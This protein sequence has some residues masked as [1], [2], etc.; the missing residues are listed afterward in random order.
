MIKR[1]MCFLLLL[2]F[3]SW[4]V[5]EITLSTTTEDEEIKSSFPKKVKVE[6][7]QD[8][9]YTYGSVTL[10]KDQKVTGYIYL[11]TV[12]KKISYVPVAPL[13][14]KHTLQGEVVV[15]GENYY[16]PPKK[17]K[18]IMTEISTPQLEVV[19]VYGTIKNNQITAYDLKGNLY[20]LKIK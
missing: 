20:Q 11:E 15:D 17:I 18:K 1:I 13:P 5:A 10:K 12:E 8:Q 2:L 14:P 9:T 19:Y 16:T 4:S 3:S 7:Y 6:G